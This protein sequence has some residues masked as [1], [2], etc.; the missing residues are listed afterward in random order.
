MI[1]ECTIKEGDFFDDLGRLIGQVR[2]I[3]LSLMQAENADSLECN[4]IMGA[5]YMLH[6]ISGDLETIKDTLYPQEEEGQEIVKSIQLTTQLF[7]E[8]P[9]AMGN[10]KQF[11]ENLLE[12]NGQ[13]V[14]DP[15][16]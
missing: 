6:D 11:M 3:A 2:F 8:K 9:E 1:H 13:T 10:L 15:Q 5:G 7:R 12:G 14:Q 4:E 16:G